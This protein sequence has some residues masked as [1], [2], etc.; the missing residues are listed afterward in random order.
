MY[1]MDLGKDCNPAPTL[2]GDVNFLGAW[3]ANVHNPYSIWI[4]GVGSAFERQNINVPVGVSG[5]YASNATI[6][7][8]PLTL[9]PLNP[10]YK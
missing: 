9:S 8:F 3:T 7:A 2:D 6:Q 10:K 4:L 1:A 5:Q